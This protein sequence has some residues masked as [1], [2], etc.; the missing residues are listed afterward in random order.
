MPGLK[1]NRSANQFDFLLSTCNC[2]CDIENDGACKQVSLDEIHKFIH[3]LDKEQ[4][5]KGK[6]RK[7]GREE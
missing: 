2:V 5:D 3:G 7:L 1:A 6:K 4:E